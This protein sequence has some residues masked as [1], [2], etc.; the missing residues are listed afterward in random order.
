M[1]DFN[2]PGVPSVPV[3]KIAKSDSRVKLIKAEHRGVSA[4][5]NV[6]LSHAS[7]EWIT[8]IDS[9]NSMRPEFLCVFVSAITHNKH[10]LSFYGALQKTQS[11]EVL[12]KPY[13]YTDLVQ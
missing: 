7:N 6:G 11:K 5:R 2:P 4:A 10:S 9:D 1:I 12:H 3:S 8:F 13:S